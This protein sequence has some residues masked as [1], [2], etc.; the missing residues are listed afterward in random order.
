MLKLRSGTLMRI[1]GEIERKQIVID[2]NYGEDKIGFSLQGYGEIK[3]SMKQLAD[4]ISEE[5]ERYYGNE[6]D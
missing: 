6:T 1:S 5:M 2:A 3:M 4:I